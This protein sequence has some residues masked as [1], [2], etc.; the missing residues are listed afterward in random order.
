MPAVGTGNSSNHS[1]ATV[2]FSD[3][4]RSD[5]YEAIPISPLIEE[6]GE[7]LGT[8][9]LHL[10]MT[11]AAVTSA[12]ESACLHQSGRKQSAGSSSHVLKFVASPPGT[13]P[14]RWRVPLNPILRQA[15]E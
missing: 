5:S 7:G 2:S 3:G 6:L 11:A 15:L 9:D 14:F 12:P 1:V 10:A 13:M 4:S 8:Q